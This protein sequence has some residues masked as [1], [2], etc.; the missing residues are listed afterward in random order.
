MVCEL[1]KNILRYFKDFYVILLNLEVILV[2]FWA[3]Y[4]NFN[5]QFSVKIALKF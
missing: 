3:L 4:I 2:I 5:Y 1:A